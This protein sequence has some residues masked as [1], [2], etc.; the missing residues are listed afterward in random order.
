[1]LIS[2]IHSYLGAVLASRFLIYTYVVLIPAVGIYGL[3]RYRKLSGYNKLLVQLTLMSAFVQD[4]QYLPF[5]WAYTNLPP[6]HIYATINI[7]Y[8]GLIFR[9]IFPEKSL[10]GRIVFYAA[11]V[12]AVISAFNTLFVQGFHSNP[13]FNIML[14]GCL[15][16]VVSLVYFRYL[17]NHPTDGNI[18]KFPPFWFVTGNLVFFAM[19]FFYLGFGT[20]YERM[21]DSV[22]FFFESYFLASGIIVLYLCYLICFILDENSNKSISS[23]D[24]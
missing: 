10:T 17:L 24:V 14:L 15:A 11:I 6:F 19:N 22:K 23:S 7:I 8:L 21:D 3:I 16:I 12:V 1:M 13:A 9:K 4:F 18:L 2:G 20:Y 5:E